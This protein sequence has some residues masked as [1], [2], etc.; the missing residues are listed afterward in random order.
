MIMV[1]AVVM[2]ELVP[3]VME[4]PKVVMLM[5]VDAIATV[6]I[7]MVIVIACGAQLIIHTITPH[8]QDTQHQQTTYDTLAIT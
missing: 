4:M 7:I 1:M 6:I 2:G 3:Q 5:P 8:P